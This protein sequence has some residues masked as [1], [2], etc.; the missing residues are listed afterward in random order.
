MDKELKKINARL[1]VGNKILG[2]AEL[3]GEQ[4]LGTAKRETVRLF[5]KTLAAAP[6]LIKKIMKSYQI[7]GIGKGCPIGKAEGGR[8][9]F[10]EAGV[11]D[12]KCMRNAINEHKRKLNEG[13]L[14]ALKKQLKI[15]Q[16]KSLKNI[17]Y[18]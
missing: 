12:D 8:I 9:G 11:V 1:K 4:A 18:L 2:A 3:T 16:N 5:K 6:N 7:A 14:G 10:S 13:D 17:L 15:N